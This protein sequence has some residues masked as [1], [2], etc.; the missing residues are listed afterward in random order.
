MLFGARRWKGTPR[1]AEG[2]PVRWVTTE[3]LGVRPACLRGVSALTLT[4]VG[5]DG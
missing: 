3:E 4:H 1:G 2:Q 5:A